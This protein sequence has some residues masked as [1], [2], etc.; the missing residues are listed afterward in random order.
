[1]GDVLKISVFNSDAGRKY[2]LYVREDRLKAFETFLLGRRDEYQ[3]EASMPGLSWAAFQGLDAIFD[4]RPKK[5]PTHDI[6]QFLADYLHGATPAVTSQEVEAALERFSC[7][8]PPD[9]SEDA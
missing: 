2:D 9:V 3:P 4:R 8:Y 5:F 1:M 6:L 7:F